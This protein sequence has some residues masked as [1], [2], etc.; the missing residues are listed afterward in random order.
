MYEPE[1]AILAKRRIEGSL[2]GLLEKKEELEQVVSVIPKDIDREFQAILDVESVSMSKGVQL[3]MSL[4]NAKYRG[5]IGNKKVQS[6]KAI[7]KEFLSG[8]SARSELNGKFIGRVPKPVHEEFHSLRKKMG[9]KM[10]E[11]TTIAAGLL[12]KYY[13]EHKIKKSS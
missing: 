3:A 6:K 2:A 7:I 11:A 13:K 8:D 10:F 9:L 5:L 12:I 4:F 1:R